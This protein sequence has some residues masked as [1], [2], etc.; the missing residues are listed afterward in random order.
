M[1]HHITTNLSSKNPV[2]NV[3]SNA[4]CISNSNGSSPKVYFDEKEVSV[5]LNV[6]VRSLQQWRYLAKELKYYKFG[7]RVRYHIEDILEYER[8]R[9]FS[10]TTQY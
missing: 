1:S 9:H 4:T 7:S 6:S 8:N 3:N 10:S 5:R 2:V